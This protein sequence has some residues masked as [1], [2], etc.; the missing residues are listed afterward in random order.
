MNKPCLRSESCRTWSI[1]GLWVAACLASWAGFGIRPA[2]AAEP[3]R[4]VAV[5]SLTPGQRMEAAL[6]AFGRVSG[7][8]ALPGLLLRAIQ[9]RTGIEQL[10]GWDR[11]RP[12]GA[13]IGADG[14]LVAPVVMVPTADPPRLLESLAPLIGA[15]QAVEPGLWKIG[16]GEFTGYVRHRNGWLLAAQ[17]PDVLEWQFEPMD[18]L[19]ELP[20][21]YD[22]A[23][24]FYVQRL[25]EVFRTMAIDLLRIALRQQ[26]EPRP[27][28][29]PAA[30]VLRKQ[31]A[32][33]QF[34][35]VEE[36]LAQAAEITVG[37][38][39]LD[40]P[41]AAAVIDVSLKAL[42]DSLLAQR[43]DAVRRA[44]S[45]F[46]GFGGSE[47]A[48]RARAALQLDESQT[49]AAQ[50][51]WTELRQAVRAAATQ[52]AA[53]AGE[54]EQAAI[55]EIAD[56]LSAVLGATADRGRF[57]VA[58]AVP[59]DTAPLTVLAAARLEQGESLATIVQ[60]LAELRGAESLGRIE[61][62]AA[63]AGEHPVHVIH[64]PPETAEAVEPLLGPRPR[65][66]LVIRESMLYVAAGPAA[67]AELEREL[68][69]SSPSPS[70]A[71]PRDEESRA[72]VASRIATPGA[73]PI[74]AEARLAKLLAIGRQLHPEQRALF[75]VAAV[76]L[77]GQDD[78]LS[79]TIDADAEGLKMQAVI[80]QGGLRLIGAG[81]LLQLLQTP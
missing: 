15:A 37:A 61:A 16:D 31:W 14:L 21:R 2:T 59:R 60:R 39:L 71:I 34:F 50:A 65:L 58:L 25:P 9:S 72:K 76:A 1:V 45:E 36:L 33:W 75:D 6:S 62:A 42:P 70:P 26:I 55:G 12:S 32:S 5:V 24:R 4:P 48:L 27:G 30:H 64:L 80:R 7:N 81:L 13:M 74:A 35:T 49:A 44:R 57:D 56:K 8:Q 77:R 23:A 43:F 29:N 63:R 18:V 3:M 53:R 20:D 40:E 10:P 66:H 68:A 67:L 79:V 51:Q 46:A 52:L 19:G 41:E 73:A 28:E 17:T 78:R 47:P 11:T 38:R 54:Q 22:L 69:S